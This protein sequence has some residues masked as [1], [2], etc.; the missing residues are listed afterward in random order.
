M[1]VLVFERLCNRF[2]QSGLRQMMLRDIHIRSDQLHD[3]PRCI[4]EGATNAMDI[5]D[6][7]VRK[8]YAKIN[9]GSRLVSDSPFPGFLE[10]LQVLRVNPLSSLLV[11]H[12]TLCRIKSKRPIGFFR[13]VS[14]FPS[15]RVVSKTAGV[16]EAL[17]FCEVG[18]SSAHGLFCLLAVLD[19]SSSAVPS[20]DFAVFVLE[21]LKRKSNQR[22]CPSFRI[23]RASMLNGAPLRMPRL[24]VS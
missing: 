14:N 17:G 11:C 2:L 21:W 5:L 7:T 23:T 24:F 16:A 3:F 19:V 8:D 4:E 20:Y 9:T 18:L 1:A 13:P 10:L 12:W 15:D 22:Y 6:R